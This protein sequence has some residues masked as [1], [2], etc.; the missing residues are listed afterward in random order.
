MIFHGF[1]DTTDRELFISKAHKLEEVLPW[2]FGILQE[3][4]DHKRNDKESNN[5]VNNEAMP[6]HYDG[7]LNLLRRRIRMAKKS[8]TRMAILS[9]SSNRQGKFDHNDGMS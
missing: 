6:M 4:K 5:V 7:F 8:R 9:K 1:A 2:T 3:V